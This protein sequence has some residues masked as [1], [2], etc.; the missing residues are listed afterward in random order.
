MDVNAIIEKAYDLGF[1]YERDYRGCSQ[2]SI[3]AIQDALGVRNDYVFK[4]GSGLATGGGLLRVGLCGGYSGGVMMMSSFFG[5]SREKIDDDREEKY[6]SFNMAVALHDLFIQK[7][8]S[9]ICRE[10]HE[11]IFGRS[12]DLWDKKE[13]KAFEEAGAHRDKCTGVVADASRWAT[14]LILKEIE[15]RGLGLEDFEYL[16]YPVQQTSRER[17]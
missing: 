14:E 17:T 8:R 2:C 9:V 12:Y 7:Y 6:C 11:C 13:R 10:I 16:K 4:A 5:R 15:T 1:E 3:A